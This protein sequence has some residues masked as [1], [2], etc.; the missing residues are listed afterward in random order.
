MLLSGIG[1]V[2]AWRRATA[3]NLRRNLLRP[4]A[5]GV[6]VVVLLLVRGR[7]AARSRR[8]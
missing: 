3:A 6:A 5:V 1:P 7:D 4:A 2:I 8:C